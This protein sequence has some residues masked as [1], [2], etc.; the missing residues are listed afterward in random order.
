MSKGLA[1][2]TETNRGLVH[3]DLAN[4][5]FG[6]GEGEG[7]AVYVY[8]LAEILRNRPALATLIRRGE[9]K[10]GETTVLNAL[11]TASKAV[12]RH[13]DLGAECAVIVGWSVL[14]D[15]GVYASHVHYGSQQVG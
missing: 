4:C 8:W 11:L 5:F 6:T 13:L 9:L 3:L 12:L 1:G 15:A 14:A 2:L 7:D 10:A